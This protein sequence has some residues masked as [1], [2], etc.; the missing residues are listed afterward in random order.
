M[1]FFL[2]DEN[3]K[4]TFINAK[5][6]KSKLIN[7]SVTTNIEQ[8]ET[9]E[10]PSVED[11]LKAS[12]ISKITGLTTILTVGDI[13]DMIED[14]IKN[15]EDY[16]ILSTLFLM[17]RTHYISIV[18]LLKQKLISLLEIKNLLRMNFY[19]RTEML[20]AYLSR[21]PE[22][23]GID[24]FRTLISRLSSM[25]SPKNDE[26]YTPHIFN[27]SYYSVSPLP[28]YYY[29]I[30]K[31]L[32]TASY[33]KNVLAFTYDGVSNDTEYLNTLTTSQSFANVYI[34][35]TI[36]TIIGY[37]GGY[38][39]YNN[40]NS[41]ASLP[42]AIYGTTTTLE[43]QVVENR[44]PLTV[45]YL[46]ELITK[47][48]EDRPD[49]PLVV[50][51]AS[52]YNYNSYLMN[53]YFEKATLMMNNNSYLQSKEVSLD[54]NDRTV[55]HEAFDFMLNGGNTIKSIYQQLYEL[56]SGETVSDDTG[57]T[58]LNLSKTAV[59]S[60]SSVGRSG[61]YTFPILNIPI[62]TTENV[63]LAS[64][65][66]IPLSSLSILGGSYLD[67]NLF[68]G[69]SSFSY[70]DTVLIKNDGVDYKF[71]IF[72]YKVPASTF[73][74]D[75]GT[76]AIQNGLYFSSKVSMD[77]MESF[78]S[79]VAS[80]IIVVESHD[81]FDRLA[82]YTDFSY[83]N[84][85]SLR[86]IMRKV[87][88]VKSLVNKNKFLEI[89]EMDK[90][91]NRRAINEILLSNIKLNINGVTEFSIDNFNSIFEGLRQINT[92]ILSDLSNFEK[93]S[94]MT[95]FD[96]ADALSILSTGIKQRISRNSDISSIIIFDLL[97]DYIDY[98]LNPSRESFDIDFDGKDIFEK[99]MRILL[100]V[101]CLFRSLSNFKQNFIEAAPE[102]K[103]SK[104]LLDYSKEN[105][106]IE[107]IP[108]EE[109]NVIISTGNVV[110]PIIKISSSSNS[111]DGGGSA[112][113]RLTLSSMI[114]T[115]K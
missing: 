110:V 97:D 71:F 42:T 22:S 9:S 4:K 66:G 112:G 78:R 33:G 2:V 90:P 76:G 102:R 17:E 43:K 67:V 6:L 1:A 48:K 96:I 30:Y 26:T 85:P 10:A 13:K 107:A 81:Y 52:L 36:S 40:Y 106:K 11:E 31:R 15:D 8:V 23:D 12:L 68:V 50:K 79:S 84:N 83:I 60:S 99:D 55:F 63:D 25:S 27:D 24:I 21:E 92:E 103:Y 98:L 49:W 59:S 44:I 54:P 3:N 95:F 47:A 16:N 114:E 29:S 70:I 46:R 41:Y 14:L 72:K 93:L 88:P 53:K 61:L 56:Y 45:D 58:S 20:L 19:N 75:F 113:G 62:P 7:L 39:G 18:Y 94:S 64:A 77:T 109:P 104:F 65:F 69:T 57:I 73:L 37:T 82:E 100:F 115:I 89:T 28:D 111:G 74:I 91:E 80:N 32:S 35:K 87:F 51:K 108:A 86:V 105:Y 34:E 101:D 5:F 38:G